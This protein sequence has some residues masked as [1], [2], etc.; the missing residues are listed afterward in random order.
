[1]E[2][3][4]EQSIDEEDMLNRPSSTSPRHQSYRA[5][6]RGGLI[7]PELLVDEDN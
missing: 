5:V 1:M 7:D 3:K 6:G 4:K 2:D